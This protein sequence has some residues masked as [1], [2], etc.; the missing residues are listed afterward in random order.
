MAADF[1]NGPEYGTTAERV[2]GFL[3][4]AN[5]SSRMMRIDFSDHQFRY[6]LVST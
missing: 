1:Y 4:Y 5:D 6:P 3:K 2:A